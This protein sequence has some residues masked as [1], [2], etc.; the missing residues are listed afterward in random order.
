M[1]TA[2]EFYSNSQN[3]VFRCYQ[4]AVLDYFNRMG[5]AGR[6]DSFQEWH[7]ALLTLGCGLVA[8]GEFE[9][10]ELSPI[11]SR[12]P[13]QI[14]GGCDKLRERVTV[15]LTKALHDIEDKVG[16]VLAAQPIL[17]GEIKHRY[18]DVHADHLKQPQHIAFVTAWGEAVGEMEALGVMENKHGVK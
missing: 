6:Y 9:F 8:T 11:W 13:H 2:I 14:V 7:S 16:C 12:L 1:D 5:G 15:E 4:S 18:G 17:L 3:P 10:A